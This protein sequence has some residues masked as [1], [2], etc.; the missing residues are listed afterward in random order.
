MLLQDWNLPR[1]LAVV[2]T[3]TN[4]ESPLFETGLRLLVPGFHA[5]EDG[6]LLDTVTGTL[7][8]N[9]DVHISTTT[10][11]WDNLPLVALSP[12]DPSV[13]YHLR[14]MSQ[15]WADLRQ[16]ALALLHRLDG[17]ILHHSTHDVDYWLINRLR[18]WLES[19]LANLSKTDDH[20][21]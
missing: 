13:A 4:P 2:A 19:R 20:D 5:P 10:V 15:D 6:H 7:R 12:I 11:H 18:S 17:G 3:T 1:V 9:L 16:M 21:G 8:D 14:A